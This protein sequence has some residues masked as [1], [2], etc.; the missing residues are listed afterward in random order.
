M[1]DFESSEIGSILS[2]ILCIIFKLL[3][4]VYVQCRK[5][6][7][8]SSITR[9]A[10]MMNFL[11]Y[12]FPLS[13]LFSN[14]YLT[15]VFSTRYRN[16]IRELD[17]DG[18]NADFSACGFVFG[19]VHS[20]KCDFLMQFSSHLT[21]PLLR[22]SLASMATALQ[23]LGPPKFN[24][25]RDYSSLPSPFLLPRPLPSYYWTNEAGRGEGEW[26]KRGCVREEE[27]VLL[28][29]HH[30]RGSLLSLPSRADG[31]GGIM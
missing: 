10:G 31:G 29:C 18:E 12:I 19:F 15:M 26:R 6:C 17:N 27:E 4:T 22:Y 14:V 24:Q 7:R 1:G 2:C 5:W 11:L 28:P 23:C 20:V 25:S 13:E 9:H 21:L 16:M 30:L 3:S 8:K